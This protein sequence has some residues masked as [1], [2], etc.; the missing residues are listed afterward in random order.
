MSHLLL[1][2]RLR[3]DL[4]LHARAADGAFDDVSLVNRLTAGLG[5]IESAEPASAL[6]RLGRAVAGSRRR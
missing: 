5:T 3:R 1:V 2:E 6:W 4:A